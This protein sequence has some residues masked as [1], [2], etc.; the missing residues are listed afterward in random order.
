MQ[1]PVVHPA[2]VSPIAPLEAA[3]SAKAAIPPRKIALISSPRCTP[4]KYGFASVE[5]LV[6]S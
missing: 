4:I 3:H 6:V 1:I 2:A 5:N